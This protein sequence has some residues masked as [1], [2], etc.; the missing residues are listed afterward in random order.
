MN[1]LY[2][3]TVRTVD[4]QRCQVEAHDAKEAVALSGL[5]PS[6]IAR[7]YPFCIAALPTPEEIAANRMTEETK[8]KLKER[9]QLLKEIRPTRRET[10]TMTVK[11]NGNLDAEFIKKQ[12]TIAETPARTVPD[13]P[14]KAKRIQTETPMALEMPQIEAQQGRLF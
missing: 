7:W 12:L 2:L 5:D 3:Y 10:K 1:R 9:R 4:R 14:L 6:T 13:A 8:A 11:Q